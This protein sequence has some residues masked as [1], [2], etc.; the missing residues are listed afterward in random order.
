MKRL[1]ALL[2][3]G[4]LLGACGG[5]GEKSGGPLKA[6]EAADRLGYEE[7]EVDPD[8]VAFAYTQAYEEACENVWS[9][10]PDGSLYYD[11]FAYTVEDCTGAMPYVDGTEFADEDEAASQGESDGYD[12]AFDYNTTSDVLCWGEDCWSRYDF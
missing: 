3:V 7:P 4:L 12:A 11:D 8:D 10:S 6:A 2:V 1:A 5:A 9:N